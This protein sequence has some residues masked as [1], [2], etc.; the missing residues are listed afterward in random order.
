[1]K[2]NVLFQKRKNIYI[3]NKFFF[4]QSHEIIFRSLTRIIQILGKKHYPVRGKSIESL[5]LKI[6][7]N[8]GRKFT[9]GGCYIEKVNESVLISI[10]K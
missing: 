8:K 4:R 6:K 5:L 2:E 3:L 10:E 9:L 7:Q 1:M